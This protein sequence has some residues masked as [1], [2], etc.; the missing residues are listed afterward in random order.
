MGVL[1]LVALRLAE[2][3]AP[4]AMTAAWSAHGSARRH[5]AHG[6]PSALADL[7]DPAFV[8]DRAHELLA[9]AWIE[10]SLFAEPSVAAVPGGGATR[11]R[12]P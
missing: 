5:Q 8:P 2:R 1:L 7:G 10:A 4:A 3:M 12:S 6:L 9:D 11:R